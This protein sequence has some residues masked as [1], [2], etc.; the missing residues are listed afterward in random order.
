MDAMDN[1]FGES[2]KQ[3]CAAYARDCY[4]EACARESVNPVRF[5]QGFTNKMVKLIKKVE[6]H[7]RSLHN[8]KRRLFFINSL[9]KVA[10]VLVIAITLAFT[11]SMSVEASRRNILDFLA[12]FFDDH[13]LISAAN[14]D[15]FAEGE[16]LNICSEDEDLLDEYVTKLENLGYS[17]DETYVSTGGAEYFIFNDPNEI[18]LSRRIYDCYLGST[19]DYNNNELSFT[20]NGVDVFWM[21]DKELWYWTIDGYTYWL[22]TDLD[23]NKVEEIVSFVTLD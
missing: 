10:A 16:Y 3:A 23:K 22:V 4:E 14:M 8:D 9:G 11:I 6:V 19:V 2:L 20:V 12:E 13:I 5:S 15:P 7:Y 21:S 17:C 18:I 1:I